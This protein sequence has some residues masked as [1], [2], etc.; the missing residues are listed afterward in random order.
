LAEQKISTNERLLMVGADIHRCFVVRQELGLSRRLRSSEKT[1]GAV[2]K[3][4]RFQYF[5]TVTFDPFQLI[6]ALLATVCST[7]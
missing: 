1:R 5:R 3:N 4:D 2:S 6:T 7:P